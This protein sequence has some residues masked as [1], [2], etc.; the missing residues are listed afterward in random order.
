[1]ALS[2]TCLISLLYLLLFSLSQSYPLSV[3]FAS[4]TKVNE[5]STKK[6]LI[7]SFRVRAFFYIID[8]TRQ[9]GR[10]DCSMRATERGREQYIKRARDQDKTGNLRNLVEEHGKWDVLWASLFGQLLSEC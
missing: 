9:E 5:L 4:I 10:P 2:A 7:S 6:K 1:M 3:P 8:P